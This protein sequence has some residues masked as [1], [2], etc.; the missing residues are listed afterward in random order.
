MDTLTFVQPLSLTSFDS[1]PSR[2][3]LG[4]AVQSVLLAVAGH[5][6]LN[7]ELGGTPEA[8]LLGELSAEQTERLYGRHAFPLQAASAG[9]QF[10][11]LYRDEAPPPLTAANE[12]GT[13][14]IL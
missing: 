12:D 9:L 2:G 10:E 5:K 7:R 1:S 13:C 11:R 6:V 3:A 4:I 8:P 14:T